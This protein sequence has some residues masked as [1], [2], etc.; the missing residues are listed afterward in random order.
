MSAVPCE[1][2]TSEEHLPFWLGEQFW[3]RLNRLEA[4]HQRAQSQ[5]DAV[6]R[7]L[8]GTRRANVDELTDAWQ[9]YCDVSAELDRTTAELEILRTRPE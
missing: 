3:D 8:D 7:G 6:R 5:H 2:K 1:L 9:R 4:Q